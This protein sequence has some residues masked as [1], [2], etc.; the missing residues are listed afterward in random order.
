MLIIHMRL[1]AYKGMYDLCILRYFEAWL[2]SFS[3]AD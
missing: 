1:M 2:I 3:T